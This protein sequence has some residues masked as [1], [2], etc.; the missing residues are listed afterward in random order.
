MKFK[1]D[2][3]LPAEMAARFSQAGHDTTT[4]VGQGMAGAPDAIVVRIC[5]DEERT[6]VTLDTDFANITAYPPEDYAGLVVFRV[7][8]QSREHLLEVGDR[9]LRSLGVE[10]IA[11]QLWIVEDARIRIRT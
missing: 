3:N 11:K 10:S 5:V 8:D 6:L 4:V 7:N 9:F 2:E 1:L